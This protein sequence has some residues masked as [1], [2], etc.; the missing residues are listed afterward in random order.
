MIRNNNSGM[1]DYFSV[2][3]IGDN[4]DNEISK[5][6][7]TMDSDKP[8]IIYEYSDINK[9]RTNRMSIYNELIKTTNDVKMITAINEKINELKSMSDIDYYQELGELYSY[10]ENMNIISNENPKGKWITCE[11]G[12]RIFSNYI[13]DFNGNG[14]QSGRKIDIDW[15]LT[16]TNSDKVNTYKRT[17]ELCIEN[18]KPVNDKEEN[19]LKNM[20]NFKA[21]FSNFKDKNEYIKVNTSFWTYAVIYNGEWIDMENTHEFVWVTNFYDMFIKPLPHDTLLTIYECTK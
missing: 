6:D 4:P 10:D 2:L 20:K 15:E 1:L 12:G 3:V 13:K 19:I 16:N 14:I 9:L 5:Y 8:Y 11:K 21:Y 18:S 17:W 7:L